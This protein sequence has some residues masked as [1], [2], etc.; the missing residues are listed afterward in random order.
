MLADALLKA[1]SMVVTG[2]NDKTLHDQFETD[3]RE[4]AST[5]VARADLETSMD[6]ETAMKSIFFSTW[7]LPGVSADEIAAKE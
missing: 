3:I 4:Y 2:T 1:I 7:R 5:A 6:A